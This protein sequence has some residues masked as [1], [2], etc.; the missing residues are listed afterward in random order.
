[1]GTLNISIPY[2][3]Y[4]NEE[5]EL[6]KDFSCQIQQRIVQGHYFLAIFNRKITNYDSSDQKNVATFQE[7][8]IQTPIESNIKPILSSQ[9][10]VKVEKNAVSATPEKS[11]T[12]EIKAKATKK[13]KNLSSS[14][15]KTNKNLN[16]SINSKVRVAKQDNVT[17]AINRSI[18]NAA[19]MAEAFD[20]DNKEISECLYLNKLNNTDINI[21]EIGNESKLINNNKLSNED[22]NNMMPN[23]KELDSYRETFD[24]SPDKLKLRYRD[25][26]KSVEHNK[27]NMSQRSLS[28]GKTRDMDYSI[29]K[30][31]L[32]KY[33]NEYKN[34]IDYLKLMVFALESKLKV[35]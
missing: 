3:I 19:Q 16:T 18:G 31:E 35:F 33:S 28:P 21:D 24:L 17:N 5:Y 22:I 10:S 23:R 26:E 15:K 7:T 2:D 27:K 32:W 1:M 14:S 25:L 4:E 20:K 6:D 8:T 30:N 13:S 34:Q 12:V 11:K 9:K 29:V